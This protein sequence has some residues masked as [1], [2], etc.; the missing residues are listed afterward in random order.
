MTLLAVLVGTPTAGAG[1]S[2]PSRTL[3]NPFVPW[4]DFGNYAFVPNGG[5]ENRGT[6][7]NL[8]NGARVVPGNEPFYVH[9]A[10]DTSSLSLP[11]GAV[12]STDG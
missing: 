2:C 12:A 3:T 8:A 4:G 9:S 1:K 10:W 7:W 11:A 6:H 5:F